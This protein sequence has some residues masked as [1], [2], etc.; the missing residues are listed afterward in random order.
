MTS[1]LLSRQKMCFV[2]FVAT[3]VYFCCDKIIVTTKIILVAAS[4]SDRSLMLCFDLQEVPAALSVLCGTCTSPVFDSPG[5]A[6]E[7]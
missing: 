7:V 4:A 6:G 1:I 3:K 2:L 5:K